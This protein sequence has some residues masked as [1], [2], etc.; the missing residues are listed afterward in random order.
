[1]A[2]NHP[3]VSGYVPQAVYNRLIEFKD[4]HGLTS[5]SQAVTVVLEQ[6]FGIG[7]FE[8]PGSDSGNDGRIT[9]L[10]QQVVRL[11]E[12]VQTLAEAF[13]S[14]QK[15][16][17]PVVQREIEDQP[18]KNAPRRRRRGKDDGDSLTPVG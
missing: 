13:Q 9:E 11:Q 4:Q 15:G 6:F 3:K 1:M 17:S 5:V 12:Q 10:E 16:G 7:R 2:T 18:V 14:H 8:L